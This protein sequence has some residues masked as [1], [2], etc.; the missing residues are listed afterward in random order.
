M[1]K[2]KLY[3]ADWFTNWLPM[4]R[5]QV[6]TKERSSHSIWVDGRLS[7]QGSLQ[8]RPVLG[9]ERWV[10]FHT[11]PLNLK[12]YITG[13]SHIQVVSVPHCSLKAVSLKSGHHEKHVFQGQGGGEGLWLSRAS[14]RVKWQSCPL[15]D[16]FQHCQNNKKWHSPSPPTEKH[17]FLKALYDNPR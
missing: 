16:L 7:T 6:E 11:H 2:F 15:D 9:I 3:F 1:P 17:P 5:G 4:H 10:K 13:F 8:T 12:A 14:S